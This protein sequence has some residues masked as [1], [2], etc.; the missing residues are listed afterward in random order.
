M[1][2]RR[3]GRAS[4]LILGVL[5][6]G[7]TIGYLTVTGLDTAA[8]AGEPPVQVI[9]YGWADLNSPITVG[10]MDAEG[11]V[12]VTYFGWTQDPLTTN[13][14]PPLGMR[15]TVFKGGVRVTQVNSAIPGVM[16]FHL[17]D[18]SLGLQL[19]E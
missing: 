10:P 18:D 11:K 14:I 16:S 1:N 6:L 8:T 7:I 5:L 3:L 12:T 15:T 19:G 13:P 2:Q 4:I 9:T 17:I